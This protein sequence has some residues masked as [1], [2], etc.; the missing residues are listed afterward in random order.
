M[1]KVRLRGTV[2]NHVVLVA[3]AVVLAMTVVMTSEG[4]VGASM[5]TSSDGWQIGRDGLELVNPVVLTPAVATKGADLYRS[6][7]QRCHGRTGS[8]GGPDAERDDPPGDLT[9]QRRAARNPDGVL[10]YKIWNGRSRP[11]MPAFKTDVSRD[12]V[13]AIVHHIK[14]LRAR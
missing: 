6:K 2:C 12:D 8:G 11:K 14:T 10:F 1:R 7:C 13:W 3:W 9:D 5:Q 4:T